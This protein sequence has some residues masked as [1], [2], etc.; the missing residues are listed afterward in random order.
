MVPFRWK[1]GVIVLVSA[2]PLFFALFTQHAWEDYFIMLRSSRNLVDG[3][4]LVFNPGERVHTFTSPLG[5]L[6]PAFCMWIAGVQHPHLTLW[7]FRLINVALLVSAA[8]L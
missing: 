4:G 8:I 6:L 2:V 1:W 5:V 7:L 3:Y